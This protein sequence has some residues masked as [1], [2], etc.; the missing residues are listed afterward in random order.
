MT[1]YQ[2]VNPREG[3]YTGGKFFINTLLYSL[4]ESIDRDT[5]Y[6]SHLWL[7][8]SYIFT[9]RHVRIAKGNLS[10]G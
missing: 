9:L 7:Q 5:L 1:I 4:Q 6:C 8:N 3:E 2:F 10:E